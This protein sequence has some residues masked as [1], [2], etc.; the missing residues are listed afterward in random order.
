MCILN[1]PRESLWTWPSSVVQL[2]SC[3]E[4]LQQDKS[5]R[6]AGSMQRL[7]CLEKRC[8]TLKS[9]EMVSWSLNWKAQIT[10]KCSGLPSMGSHRVGHDW[11]DLAAAAVAIG[12]KPRRGWVFPDFYS[13]FLIP[14]CPTEVEKLHTKCC[15][16]ASVCWSASA[17]RE[18]SVESDLGSWLQHLLAVWLQA[19]H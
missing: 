16:Q 8:V 7:A 6:D 10:G 17:K 2:S 3:S 12:K 5:P 1:Q 4:A 15:H 9:L 13:K 19:S 14:A 11:S 18:G